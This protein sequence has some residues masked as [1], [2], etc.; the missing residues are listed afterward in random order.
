[1]QVLF[2]NGKGRY[3]LVPKSA[4]DYHDFQ[5]CLSPVMHGNA[6]ACTDFLK[7]LPFYQLLTF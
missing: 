6:E 1:M 5:A 3:Y 7:N 4:P 2:T